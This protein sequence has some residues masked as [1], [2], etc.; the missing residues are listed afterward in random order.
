[1]PDILILA[2][3]KASYS[4]Q[5][6]MLKPTGFIAFYFMFFVSVCNFGSSC[7]QLKC[8]LYLSTISKSKL[9]KHNG[10]KN[11]TLYFV[12]IQ[13]LRLHIDYAHIVFYS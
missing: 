2:G 10:L 6:I 12:H 13:Y 7:L 11:K 5:A 8:I 9:L 3:L 4:W 1:M